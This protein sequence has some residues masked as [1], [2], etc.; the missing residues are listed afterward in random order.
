MRFRDY[1]SEQAEAYARHRPGYPDALS[2]HLATLAP[3]RERAWDCGTGNGQVA[4]M[5]A[6]HFQQVIA[7][8][9]SAEQIDQAA[10]HERV[11]YRVEKAEHTTL[12]D[13]SVDL[14]TVGTAM[15]WFDFDPFFEEV[16]R[17][18]RSDAV[19]AAW[20]YSFPKITPEIERWLER[21]FRRTLDGYWPERIRYVEDG[22][23]SLPFPFD[24]IQMPTFTMESKWDVPCMVGFLASWSGTRRWLDDAGPD[25]FA[26]EVETLQQ[27]W[28]PPDEKRMIRWPLFF[29]V[30][31][32]SK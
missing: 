3:G 13:D 8:D 7:T 16:R 20:T 17:V 1:F 32:V 29:R 4:V 9:A 12:A 23:R 2:A 28:G 26:R 30:G 25:P 11:D 5:L 27:L 18:G 24:E 6:E 22:Y 19:L 14:I 15:H 21:Y 10:P 31:R